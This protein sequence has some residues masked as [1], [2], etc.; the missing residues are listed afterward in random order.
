MSSRALGVLRP[1]SSVKI[2]TKDLATKDAKSVHLTVLCRLWIRS[3]NCHIPDRILVMVKRN[4]KMYADLRLSNRYM[5]RQLLVLDTG[6]GPSVLVKF[7]LLSSLY[8]RIT[9][10]PQMD[11]EDAKNNPLSIF[12]TVDLVL[13]G[14]YCLLHWEVT[15][16]DKLT[17]PV[18][19]GGDFCDCFREA[20]RPH[21]RTVEMMDGSSVP[22]VRK[23]WRRAQRKQVHL[24]A[25]QSSSNRDRLSTKLQVVHY[26]TISASS[27]TLV[28][29]VP[30][31]HV[32]HTVQP[33]ISFYK[34]F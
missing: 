19:L 3:R 22:I 30:A 12:G 28:S 33:L 31:Q 29:V 25:A 24:P 16:C 26:L 17:A 18:A 8:S 32:L 20:V 1:R 6:A 7:L 13:R 2:L 14:G 34:K 10:A 21:Y 15:V 9:N 11:N 4:Y 27:Q 5:L 23:P